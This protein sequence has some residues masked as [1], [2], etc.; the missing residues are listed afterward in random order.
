MLSLVLSLLTAP[1]MACL[2]P[3]ASLTAE[4]QQCCREMA[5]H[6]GRMDMDM[7]SSHSCC[8]PVVRDTDPYLATFRP[9]VSGV[10]HEM[11]AVLPIQGQPLQVLMIADPRVLSSTHA[12]P[13]SPPQTISILRI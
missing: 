13:E 6:C 1:I 5:E 12:P 7:P 11:P 4:E 3:G 2:W 8:R 10:H 9:S